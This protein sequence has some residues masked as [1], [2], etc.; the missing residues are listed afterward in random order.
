MVEEQAGKGI[1]GRRN[2]TKGRAHSGVT[3]EGQGNHIQI[4][5]LNCQVGGRRG[6][7]E[8]TGGFMHYVELG[9]LCR[10]WK[11]I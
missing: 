11:I 10:H 2:D 8:L 5:I 9:I 6:V 1:T 3:R 7:G 4:H